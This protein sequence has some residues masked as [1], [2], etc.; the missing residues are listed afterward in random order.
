[1]KQYARNACGTVGLYHILLNKIELKNDL[2]EESS[3]VIDF[4]NESNQT[5][6]HERGNLFL[7]NDKIKN[8]HKKHV[9]SGQ[10]KVE[11]E[12]DSHFVAFIEKSFYFLFLTTKISFFAVFMILSL[13]F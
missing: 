9:S 4:Y 12:V 6:S 2:F 7:K 5:N 1:M 3:P 8:V 11:E 10:S 13:N